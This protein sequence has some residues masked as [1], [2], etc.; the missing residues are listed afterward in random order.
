[1]PGGEPTA[2][3]A[4]PACGRKL[5]SLPNPSVDPAIFPATW[6]TKQ[7]GL[8][9]GVMVCDAGEEGEGILVEEKVGEALLVLVELGKEE[10]EEADTALKNKTQKRDKIIKGRLNAPAF[11]VKWDV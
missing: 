6:A 9:V 4:P 5:P 11:I 8:Y 1:M 2:R 3:I 10:G 7:Y